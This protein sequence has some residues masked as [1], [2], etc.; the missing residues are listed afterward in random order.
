M[1]ALLLFGFVAFG[2]LLPSA[3]FARPIDESHFVPIGGI[4]QWISIR[5]ENVSNPVLLVVHGG[6]GEAQWPA[7]EIYTPWEKAFTLVQ[8]DQRGAGHTFGRYGTQTP[9]VKLEQIAKDGV[10]L[11]AYSLPHTRQKEGHRPRP[12]V[13]IHRGD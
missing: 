4:D 13:G 8:W 10:E 9:Q 12:F 11:A 2:V 1:K 7:A 5:G 6:P 3:S